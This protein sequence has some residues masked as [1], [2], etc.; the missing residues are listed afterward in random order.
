MLFGQA[1]ICN[2]QSAI[3]MGPGLIGRVGPLS[4]NGMRMLS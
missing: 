3:N 2:L 1:E 4:M